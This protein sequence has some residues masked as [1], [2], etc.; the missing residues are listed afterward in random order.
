MEI[1]TRSEEIIYRLRELYEKYGYRRF[2]MSK[3][4]EYSFY[5]EHKSFL[6]TENIISFND[7]DG[8]LLALKPDITLSI[9]KNARD[10]V[11]T[12]V[13][14]NESVYR[15][16]RGIREYKEIQQVGLEY[17]GNV[18]FYEECETVILAVKSMASLGGRYTLD[19]SHMGF[20]A[21]AITGLGISAAAGA[22]ILE[23]LG[24]KDADGIRRVCIS[25]GLGED[26]EERMASLADIH[27]PF[28]KAY[29]LASSLFEGEEEKRALSELCAVYS[30]ACSCGMGENINLDFSIINDMNY[31]NGIVFQGYL[32]NVPK[33]VLSGGR[34]D[35]LLMK[36]GKNCGAC[37]FALYLDLIEL[38]REGAQENEYDVVMLYDEK[39]DIS[40]LFAAAEDYRKKDMRVAV[41]KKGEDAPK[42]KKTVVFEADK[43]VVI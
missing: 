43:E 12:R 10:D 2:K 3:F 40:S 25:E 26:I 7:L 31:Y 16:S 24:K 11:S 37:G 1:F 5:M 17:I 32:E 36:L 34:Y 18:G 19:L 14:Y 20:I 30:F 21:A 15:A 29:K 23:S 28:E 42:A 13:Y 27:G 8:R 39:S 22:Q 35:N 9:A 6:T 4:E 41:I 33:S 38:Y